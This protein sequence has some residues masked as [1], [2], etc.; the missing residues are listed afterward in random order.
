[1]VRS[2]RN[3]ALEKLFI[4]NLETDQEEELNIVDETVINP[5]ASLMQKNRDTNKIRI[6]FFNFMRTNIILYL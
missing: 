2:E 4:R 1:M 6:G 3:D 5:G